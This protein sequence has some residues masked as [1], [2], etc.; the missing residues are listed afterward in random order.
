MA[1]NKNN[2]AG[3]ILM[4]LVVIVLSACGGGDDTTTLTAE[5]LAAKAETNHRWN[6]ALGWCWGITGAFLIGAIIQW[7]NGKSDLELEYG[8]DFGTASSKWRIAPKLFW[9]ALIISLV[10]SIVKSVFL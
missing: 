5:E 3:F 8:W 10:L 4:A 2:W 9:I 7:S 1:K 6:V